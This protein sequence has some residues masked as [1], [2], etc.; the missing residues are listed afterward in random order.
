MSKTYRPYEP[1]QQLLLP[2]SLQDWLP[3]GPH[4]LF[5][6]RCGRG[7]GPVGH[8]GPV[9]DGGAWRSSPT[10][11]GCWS[12]CCYTATAPGW[13]S[14]RRIA[15]RPPRGHCVPGAGGE[16]H[17]DFRTISDFRREN[18]EALSGLFVQ[19]LELCKKAETGWPRSRRSKPNPS[20][21]ARRRRPSMVQMPT[22]GRRQPGGAASPGRAGTRHL[23]GDRGGPR[24]PDRAESEGPGMGA[25]VTFTIPTVEEAGTSSSPGPLTWGPSITSSSLSRRRS[26]R[27]GSG[28]RCA[29][30]GVRAV[31]AL[32][33]GRPDHR[34]C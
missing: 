23:Q 25:R 5:H 2:A 34:L 18:A 16:Q 3:P 33:A 26:W 6:L 9:S 10:I 7:V 12:R 8:H 14:S 19:V 1:E 30:G 13:A 21:V 31:R 11:P 32:R 24:G 27:R 15:G 4:G 29:S 20:S 17:L 28:R 22:A